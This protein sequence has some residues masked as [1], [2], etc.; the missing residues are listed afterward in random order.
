[1]QF[2]TGLMLGVTLLALGINAAAS[3]QGYRI[4]QMPG[5][6]NRDEAPD[7]AQPNNSDL[8]T[9]WNDDEPSTT[10]CGPRPGVVAAP[11]AG[12]VIDPTKPGYR[13]PP[14]PAARMPDANEIAC[15]YA[16]TAAANSNGYFQWIGGNTVIVLQPLLNIEMGRYQYRI[17]PS[18]VR[19][20][21]TKA[22][23][24][25]CNYVVTQV[26]VSGQGLS[27]MTAAF[28]GAVRPTVVTR[29]DQFV[30]NG[31]DLSSASLTRAWAS[32][33]RTSTA[34]AD[35]QRRY[36]EQAEQSRQ[37]RE[38]EQRRTLGCDNA[39]NPW[40]PPPGC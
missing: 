22:P 34:S 33:P 13:E 18:S 35:D 14:K 17:A 15:V 28:S 5:A 37:W 7:R 24:H 3:A 16:R 11:P 32:A 1:M 26:A 40:G 8:Y 30:R 31:R 19:C 21:K 2:R 39:F 10:S 12:T 27:G 25:R 20:V 38:E 23:G 29:A 4:N 9:T 6:Y 36:A